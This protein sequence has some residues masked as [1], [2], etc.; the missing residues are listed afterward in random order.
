MVANK[1]YS[2]N[3][4]AS[5]WRAAHP[6]VGAGV[7]GPAA[8]PWGEGLAPSRVCAAEG[9][10]ARH[11]RWLI[12]WTRGSVLTE[13][14]FALPIFLLLMAWSLWWVGRGSEVL[15]ST[16][17]RFMAARAASVAATPEEALLR[18]R[19]IT[20]ATH[21]RAGVVGP[22]WPLFHVPQPHAQS[23]GGDNPR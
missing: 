19:V 5:G 1:T 13:L 10:A 20:A 2:K 22:P 16:Y 17:T 23:T 7:G 18:A 4:W 14:L 9:C 21:V 11:P 8:K 12:I 3:L 15:L 6:V